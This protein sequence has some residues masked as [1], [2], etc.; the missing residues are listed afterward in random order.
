MST[1]ATEEGLRLGPEKAWRPDRQRHSL[2]PAAQQDQRRPLQGRPGRGRQG[3]RQDRVRREGDRE[4]R[5]LRG[6]DD[7]HGAAARR[8]RRPQGDVRPHRVRPQVQ[9]RRGGHR[10]EQ[11][12]RAGTFLL[13]IHARPWKHLQG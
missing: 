5:Q 13:A 4:G 7:H 3:R 6:A 1:G 9:E 10:L 11:R 8:P 2:R 12:G